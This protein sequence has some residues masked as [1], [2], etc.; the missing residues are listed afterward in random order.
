VS[1]A[2]GVTWISVMAAPASKARQPRVIRILLMQALWP[3]FLME[4]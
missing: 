4:E 1:A 2:A 3:S